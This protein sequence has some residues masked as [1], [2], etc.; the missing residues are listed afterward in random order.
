V[1]DNRRQVLDMLSAGQITAEEADRLI[2]A[3]EGGPAPA[4]ATG[5]AERPARTPRYLRVIANIADDEEGP[6][7][8]NVRAP[9][10]LL[11]AGVRL[12]SL[13]PPKAQDEVNTALREHAGFD[14]S[15]IKP[16]NLDE[17]ID[18]LGDL[19]VDVDGERGNLTVR[20]FCE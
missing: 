3:I 5:L 17:L 10:Q 15:Q 12:A 6:I 20:I 13:I 2:A 4:V 7:K 11:R 9:L 16:E 18:H 8:V 14:L 1:S 19:T